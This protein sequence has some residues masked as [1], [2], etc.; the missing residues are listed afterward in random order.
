VLG[1]N[2]IRNGAASQQQVQVLEDAGFLERTPL[3]YYILAEAAVREDGQRLGPVGSTIVAEVPVGLVRRSEHSILRTA[4]WE[5]TLPSAQ[6]GTF[7]L[8]DL[9]RVARVLRQQR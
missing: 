1:P 4:G 7:T 5:P 9:L 8:T 2:Q 6:P 3:W